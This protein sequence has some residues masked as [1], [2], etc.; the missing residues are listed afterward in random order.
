[1]VLI[2]LIAGAVTGNG[3]GVVSAG[4]EGAA[5]AVQTVLGFAGLMCF[6]S[7]ILAL[8]EKGGLARI[9]SGILSPVLSLVFGKSNASEHIAMNVTANLLGMGNAATPAGIRAMQE[10][11]KENNSDIP[12]RAMCIFAVMN[13]AS[14]QII[15]TTVASMRASAGS[16]TPFDIMPAVWITSVISLA[17]AVGMTL[18]LYRKR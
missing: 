12:S 5:A 4:L 13:T 1:M 9:I 16:S 8:C 10:L 15:P 3:E 2:S 18:L 6:W 17:A 14:L 7:G 11:D